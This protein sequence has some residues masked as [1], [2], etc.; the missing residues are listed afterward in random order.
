MNLSKKSSPHSPRQIRAAL[1]F[2]GYTISK[3]ARDYGF[4]VDTVRKVVATGG[5]QGRITQAINA[6]IKEVI[7]A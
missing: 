3:F 4:N 6:K 2:R 7:S 5:G 1:L